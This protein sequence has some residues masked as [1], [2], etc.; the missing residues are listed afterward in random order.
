M[1]DQQLILV[2]EEIDKQVTKIDRI[3]DKRGAGGN[4]LMIS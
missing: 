1:E 4:H 2:K 3:L